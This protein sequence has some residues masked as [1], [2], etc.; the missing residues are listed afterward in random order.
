[1]RLVFGKG[2]GGG[3]QQQDLTPADLRCAPDTNR[4][5]TVLL[6]PGQTLRFEVR[7]KIDLSAGRH[8]ARFE[9][10]SLG[11]HDGDTQFVGGVLWVEPGE[12]T[13]K[14]GPWWKFW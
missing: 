3:E 9:Y 10:H 8:A 14:K 6:A 7:K 4:S 2:Q 11:N 13:V 5:A 1:L 12:L